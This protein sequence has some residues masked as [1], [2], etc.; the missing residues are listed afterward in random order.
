MNKKNQ[1]IEDF[2][3]EQ[4]EITNKDYDIIVELLD[5]NK[6]EI[7]EDKYILLV[8]DNDIIYKLFILFLYI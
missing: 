8:S 5:K 7:V 4:I 6:R 3:N 2:Y 1:F